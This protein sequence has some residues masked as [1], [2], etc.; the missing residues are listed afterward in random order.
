MC[1]NLKNLRKFRTFEEK[2]KTKSTKIISYDH[3]HTQQVI[4]LIED[5][6]DNIPLHRTQSDRSTAKEIKTSLYMLTAIVVSPSFC[7]GLPI[8]LSYII[9]YLPTNAVTAFFW[10]KTKEEHDF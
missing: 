7:Y 6:K 2:R 10:A 5:N 4:V 3:K 9:L 1:E 8:C